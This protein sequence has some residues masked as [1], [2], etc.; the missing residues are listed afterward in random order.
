M[1]ERQEPDLHEH[2]DARLCMPHIIMNIINGALKFCAG[3][4]KW[5]PNKF[6][7]TDF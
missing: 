3:K 2:F 7:Q 5:K 6:S 4:T 1:N